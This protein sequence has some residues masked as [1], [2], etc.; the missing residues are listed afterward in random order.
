MNKLNIYFSNEL[1]GFVSYDINNDDFI[2]EYEEL[3][4]KK[5]FELTPHIKFNNDITSNTIKRFIENLLP[6]GTGREILSMNYHI[7]KNN[8][9]GLIQAIGNETTGALT[10][11]NSSNPIPTSFRKINKSELA[12]RIR[13]RK[14]RPISIWDEKPRLSIAGVQDKLPIS[15]IDGEFGFGEGDLASTHILKF[16]KDDENIVLNEYISL[17]LASSAGLSVADAKIINV[18]DQE[19]LLVKRFD[20]EIISSENVKRIHII[21]ACQALDL[22]VIQKYERTFGSA[23]SVKDYREGTS[24]Q[25]IFSLVDLCDLPIVAKKN[26]ITWICVNLCLGNSD[27]HGKNLSFMIDTNKMSLS[28]FYDIV[29]IA[30]YKDKYDIGM[31]MAIDDAFNYDELGS[32]DFIEFCKELNINLKAFVKEFKRVSKAVNRSLDNDKF[33]DLSDKNKS[34]FLGKYKDDVQQRTEKLVKVIDYCIEYTTS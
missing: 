7:S 8:I 27:A 14:S 5:G 19:V 23:D 9:F 29:N 24:Y 34:E 31:A 32:Y 13:D 33:F 6:E 10:F 15:I 25:K 22:S 11:N 2:V 30:I 18:E 3:W 16:E 1:V 20:R 4:I 17:K 21:D 12:Q 28:P 26:L